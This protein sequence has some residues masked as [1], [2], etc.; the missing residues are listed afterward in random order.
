LQNGAEGVT[1]LYD[2]IVIRFYFVTPFLIKWFAVSEQY[3][4]FLMPLLL[5]SNM[6]ECLQYHKYLS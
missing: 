1:G 5:V 6:E 3:D 4:V 2:V